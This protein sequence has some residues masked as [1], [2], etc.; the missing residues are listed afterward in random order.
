MAI[1]GE[2]ERGLFDNPN[3]PGPHAETM[4]LLASHFTGMAPHAISFVNH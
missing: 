1:D 2:E 3:E 4:F